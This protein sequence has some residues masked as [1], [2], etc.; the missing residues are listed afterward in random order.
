VPALGGV[1]K[2]VEV[3]RGG[4]M[5]PAVKLSEDKATWPSAKQ[6]WRHMRDGEAAGDVIA[7][8]G[9]EVEGARPLLHPVVRGGE[10]VGRRESFDTL[11]AQC[12]ASIDALPA[13]VRRLKGW[14]EYPVAVSEA[15]RAV[16]EKATAAATRSAER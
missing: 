5:V 3:E 6:V 1:Y 10:R 4:V 14:D 13:G 7:L 9:E 8:A 15:L 12:R 2:L 16:R 11:R